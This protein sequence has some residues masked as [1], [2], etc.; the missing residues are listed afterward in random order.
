M[1][2]VYPNDQQTTQQIHDIQK[3]LTNLTYLAKEK[4]KSG[5]LL[6]AMVLYTEAQHLSFHAGEGLQVKI[7][8]ENTD[9]ETWHSLNNKIVELNRLITPSV[10]F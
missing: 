6:E 5:Q 8:N 10:H 3:E 9:N 4:E 1:R 2:P 7:L